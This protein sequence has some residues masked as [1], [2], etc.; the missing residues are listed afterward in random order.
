MLPKWVLLYHSLVYNFT[1]P[2][3]L[4]DR[5]FCIIPTKNKNKP[6][7][8]YIIDNKW[9][10]MNG[11]NV[12]GRDCCFDNNN[13][14]LYTSNGRSIQKMDFETKKVTT[15]DKGR[16]SKIV[17]DNKNNQ[18]HVIGTSENSTFHKIWYEKEN[19]F[20]MI[21]E[22]ATGSNNIFYNYVILDIP[23]KNLIL[24]IGGFYVMKYGFSNTIYSYCT[25]DK[26]WST[27]DIIKPSIYCFASAATIDGQYV[28][29][30]GG[31]DEDDRPINKIFVMDLTAMTIKQSKINCPKHK[32]SAN[33]HAIIMNNGIKQNLITHGF[34][35][36]CYKNYLFKAMKKLPLY[37]IDLVTKCYE[38][39]YVHLME[40]PSGTRRGGRHWKMK[41]D[42][43]INNQYP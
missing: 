14:I 25:L 24:L 23:S 26:K 11:Y 17:Y 35:R 38:I 15:M 28:I 29:L 27:L 9:K 10:K 33:F 18:L 1:G 36:M 4:N 43:I 42:D 6:L 12:S 39:E 40:S 19:K 31:Y 8:K 5:E 3:A 21:H 41:V 7:Y 34:I 32:N 16:Y 2:I 22:F 37:L 13:E 20:V 30:F